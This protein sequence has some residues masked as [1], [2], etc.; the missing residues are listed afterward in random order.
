VPALFVDTGGFYAAAD[1]SDA[2]H[3]AAAATFEARGTQGEL[4]TTDHVVIETWL[5]LRARLTRAEA[6][7]FWDAMATGAVRVLGVSG[8]DFAR[9]RRIA[10]DWPDQ[11]FS[12]VDC[13]SFA[14]M[15]RL[16]IKEAL[17]FDVHF[18]IYRWGPSRE[19]AFRV[20]P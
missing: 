5:L 8:P 19:K 12:I 15:E 11:D 3:A 7:R 4:V 2:R 17:A 18:R 20:L 10:R 1:R 9:A 16:R 14:V 13:T 6:L